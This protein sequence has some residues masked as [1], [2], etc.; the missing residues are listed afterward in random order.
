[1]S[2]VSILMYNNDGIKSTGL[3]ST[4]NCLNSLGQMM[5]VAPKD[6]KS[7]IGKALANKAIKTG[8]TTIHNGSQEAFNRNAS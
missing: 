4:R 5:V 7:D 3:I 1:M 2:I 8:K 6:E